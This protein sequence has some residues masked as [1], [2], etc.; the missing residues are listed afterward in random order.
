MYREYVYTNGENFSLPLFFLF[1][2]RQE[3]DVFE[4][5]GDVT[6]FVEGPASS[7]DVRGHPSFSTSA[8]TIR[9][10]SIFVT[11]FRISE[12][13]TITLPLQPPTLLPPHTVHY[14]GGVRRY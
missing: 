2:K 13:F 1:W 8:A 12:I 6:D 11:Q 4:T 10:P 3:P 9:A 7:G 14:L 5:D